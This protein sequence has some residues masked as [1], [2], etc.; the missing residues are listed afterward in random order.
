LTPRRLV[1]QA[2]QACHTGARAAL[3]GCA[4]R[5]HK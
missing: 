4:T 2:F 5:Q 1:A 3:K